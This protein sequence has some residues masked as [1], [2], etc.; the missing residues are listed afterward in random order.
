MRCLL[1]PLCLLIGWQ[2]VAH[3]PRFGILSDA[4]KL[5]SH[6]CSCFHLKSPS[7]LTKLTGRISHLT[8]VLMKCRQILSD[9]GRRD[10]KSVSKRREKEKG[11]KENACVS[12]ERISKPS[13]PKDMSAECMQWHEGEGAGGA[14]V[15]EVPSDSLTHRLLQQNTTHTPQSHHSLVRRFVS[16]ETTVRTSSHSTPSSVC[17]NEFPFHLFSH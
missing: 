8:S 6:A 17:L 12:R 14:A 7:N 11:G 10:G 9:P 2:N 3:D 15:N 13:L 5:K 16:S 1:P 4:G